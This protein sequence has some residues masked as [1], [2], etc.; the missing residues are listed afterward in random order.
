MTMTQL[1]TEYLY[2]LPRTHV[3]ALVGI[4]A[5]LPALAGEL[6][7]DVVLRLAIPYGEVIWLLI[8]LWNLYWFLFRF[9]Y[10]AGIV[11]DID[12]GYLRWRTPLRSGVLPIAALRCA[13]PSHVFSNI[14]VF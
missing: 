10:A 8:A 2:R 13:R 12:S 11:A 6:I 7:F 14:E 9:A 5:I 1:R 4:F 3:L